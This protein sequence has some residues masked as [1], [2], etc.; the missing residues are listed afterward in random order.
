MGVHDADGI[1][2]WLA[3]NLTRNQ[4]INQDDYNENLIWFK[5]DTSLL[6]PIRF[7]RSI[8]TIEFEDYALWE[9][10]DDYDMVNLKFHVYGVSKLIAKQPP[11]IDMEYFIAFGEL[12][13]YIRDEDGNKYV[14]DGMIGIGEDKSVSINI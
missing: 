9:V 12:E 5:N 1:Q 8:P 14:L 6:P 2:K 7:T 4:S 10:R 3:F 11:V 13:G